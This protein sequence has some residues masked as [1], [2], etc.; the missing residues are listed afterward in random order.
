MKLIALSD[1]QAAALESSLK[2]VQ[3]HLDTSNGP[4]AECIPAVL[5]QLE[6][7]KEGWSR[8]GYSALPQANFKRIDHVFDYA[9]TFVDAQNRYNDVRNITVSVVGEFILAIMGFKSR[10]T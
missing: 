5:E 1:E 3:E 9:R 4:M 10:G 7:Q 2:A 6:L 8:P